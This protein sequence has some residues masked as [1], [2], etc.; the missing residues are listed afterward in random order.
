[1][2]T[3]GHVLQ[4]LEK[5]EPEIGHD[6]LPDIMEGVVLEKSKKLLADDNNQRRKDR[7]VQQ[8]LALFYCQHMVKYAHTDN[9]GVGKV[10]HRDNKHRRYAHGQPLPVG[11]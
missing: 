2:K 9:I 7:Q 8:G 1:M 11:L 10:D 4:M 5:L 3:N 6:P